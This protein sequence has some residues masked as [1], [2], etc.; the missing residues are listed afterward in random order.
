MESCVLTIGTITRAIRG[1]KLLSAAGIPARLVKS[2]VGREDGGCA[3]G[4]EIASADMLE[5]ARILKGKGIEYT[6]SRGGAGPQ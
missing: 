1:R 5:A 3:Y 6:W 4:L 2:V